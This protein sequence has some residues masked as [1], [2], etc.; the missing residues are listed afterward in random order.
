MHE[1]DMP[2]RNKRRH[3]RIRGVYYVRFCPEGG[4]SE[5]DLAPIKNI[6]SGGIMFQ[7]A[8]YF[9]RGSKMD[10]E[11]LYPFG[12]A[13]RICKGSVLRCNKVKAREDLYEVVI[14]IAQFEEDVKNDL[15]R[16]METFLKKRKY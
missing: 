4:N 5:W 3:A 8:N 13:G 12:T 10:I 11:I 1:T 6:G 2:E 14:D 9:A 15:Y 7:T 16:T